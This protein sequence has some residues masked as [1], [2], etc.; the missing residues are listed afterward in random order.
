MTAWS[1]ASIVTAG[2]VVLANAGKTQMSDASGTIETTIDALATGDS[3]SLLERLAAGVRAWVAPEPAPSIA[4]VLFL[5][6][7]AE[8][9]LD[10][11]SPGSDAWNAAGERFLAARAEYQRLFALAAM[12]A[13]GLRRV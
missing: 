8:H 4:R 2:Q 12:D 3:D 9:D 7:R 11:L 10:A 6:R 1:A 5:W 13:E